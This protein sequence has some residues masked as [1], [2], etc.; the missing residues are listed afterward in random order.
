MYGTLPAF[1]TECRAV[2]RH[3]W[4]AG[5]IRQFLA[6]LVCPLQFLDFESFT[7][8][9]RFFDSVRLCQQVPFQFGLHVLTAS[10]A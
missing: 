5:T 7:T 2:G 4:K 8:T 1:Y 3:R 9:M 10:R 6:R